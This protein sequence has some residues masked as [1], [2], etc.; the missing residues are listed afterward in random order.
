MRRALV[1]SGGGSKGAW[2][3]GAL[4]ALAESDSCHWDSIHGVSVGAIN[5]A[6]LAMHTPLE[7]VLAIERLVGIWNNITSTEQIYK[8][9]LPFKLNYISSMF[10]GS[11]N[12]GSP[13]KTLVENC[14]NQ[15]KLVESGVKLTVGAVSVTT[16]KYSVID[17]TN[18]KIFDYVLASSH[19]PMVFEPMNIDDEVWV[20]G[21]IRHQ[22]PIIEALKEDPDEI[23]VIL[24]SPLGAINRTSRTENNQ[25]ISAPKVAIRTVDILIDQIYESDCY[26]VLRV[27]NG[28]G[29]M[30]KIKVRL[31]APAVQPSEDSMDFSERIIKPAIAMGYEEVKKAL[32]K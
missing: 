8:P 30:K 11:L 20:D 32:G 19:L 21:G 3:V 2:Q 4:K 29:R 5:A 27:M 31:F 17:Q 25:L 16:G 15:E 13:L 9:W 22:I 23:D 18:P 1:L 28:D 24:T 12:T 10:K 26:D 7:Q 6:F 14:W